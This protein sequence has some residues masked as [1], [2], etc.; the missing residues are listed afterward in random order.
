MTECQY[1]KEQMK[2]EDMVCVMCGYDH[3]TGIIN[4]AFKEQMAKERGAREKVQ[5]KKEKLQNKGR[6]ISP[7][8]KKFIFIGLIIT[9]FSLF[10]KHN[11]NISS[12][13]SETSQSLAKLKKIKFP[14]TTTKDKKDNKLKKIELTDVNSFKGNNKP[15]RKKDLKVEGIFFDPR[16]K[17]FVTINGK[18]LSEGETAG[19]ITVRQ[20][21]RD[22]VELIIYGENK[23]LKIN[24]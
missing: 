19:N 11:F 7:S 6:G 17:S 15:L 14:E 23:I 16:N 9:A 4:N 13:V 24:Q 1:C 21:N 8:V 2:D 20:I 18:I 12:V 3:K 5:R 10:Y 22:S